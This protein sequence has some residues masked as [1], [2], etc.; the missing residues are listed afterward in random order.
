[1]TIYS[2]VYLTVV[3]LCFGSFVTALGW[4]EYQNI[5]SV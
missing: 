2:I 1:M 4:A 5:G 3:I